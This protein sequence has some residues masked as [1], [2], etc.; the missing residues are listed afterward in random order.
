MNFPL[1]TVLRRRYFVKAVSI[2]SSAY[3]LCFV[4]FLRTCI[5][6]L[7][8]QWLS[9]RSICLLLSDTILKMVKDCNLQCIYFLSLLIFWWP[10]SR[11][12]RRDWSPCRGPG[13]GVGL[14][15]Q[16]ECFSALF[17]ESKVENCALTSIITIV[18]L[19]ISPYDFV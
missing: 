12:V 6:V 17:S 3:G 15:V 14:K 5:I 9:K 2:L 13:T 16:T 19:F 1:S 11:P 8:F 10:N 7:I 18:G 4:L